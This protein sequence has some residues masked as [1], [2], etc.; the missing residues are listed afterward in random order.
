MGRHE[1]GIRQVHGNHYCRQILACTR[2]SSSSVR[3]ITNYPHV[4]FFKL[5][6][7]LKRL[8]G[9]REIGLR[10]AAKSVI[11]ERRLVAVCVGDAGEVAFGVVGGV[12]MKI[13][14]LAA[15]FYFLHLSVPRLVQHEHVGDARTASADGGAEAPF[16]GGIRT[17]GLDRDFRQVSGMQ[18]HHNG[19]GF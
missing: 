8:S 11:G 17:C 5:P 15:K 18:F 1:C 7:Y 10:D 6:Q 16:R 12:A 19:Q 9:R 3:L 14:R 2:D 4:A 13:S